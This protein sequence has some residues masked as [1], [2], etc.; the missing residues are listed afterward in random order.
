MRW[1][2]WLF[3]SLIFLSCFS[4]VPSRA[5]NSEQELFVV[6]QKAFEDGFYDIAPRY[7]EQLLKEYPRTEKRVPARLLLGQC[8]FF[9]S[10][11]LKA[12]EIFHELLEYSEFKDATLFWL[13]ETYLKGSDYLQAEKQFEQLI[14]VYPDSEYTPQAYYSLGWTYFAE[15]KL[16]EAQKTLKELLQK[17]PDHQFAEDALFKLGEIE[18]N[19]HNYKEAIGYFSDYADKYRDSA[20]I[21]E[22]YFYIG[23]AYYYLEDFLTAITYY[24]K[25]AQGAYDEKLTLM[26]K[27][28]L[29]WSYLKLGKYDLAKNNLEEAVEFSKQKGIASDDVYLGLASLYYEIKVYDQAMAAYTQLIENFADSSRLPEA[30]L[31]RANIYYQ[32]QKYSEAISDYQQVIAQF[33]NNSAYQEIVEKAYFGL[34][35][36]YLKIGKV[37][38]SIKT[39]QAIKDQSTSKTIK[40]SALTQIGDA[41]QDL[42]ELEKA[43]TV[44]DQILRDYP[45][46]VY[47]D[48]VQYRQGIALLKMERIEAATLSFQGL[49][50]NFPQSKYIHDTYYYLALAYFKK[51]NWAA[52]KQYINDFIKNLP[53]MDS[54]ESQAYY[55]LALSEFNTENYEEAL[56]IFQQ[57]IKKYP[58]ESSM[59]NNCEINVAKCYYKTDHAKEAL[60]IFKSLVER[61]PQSEI[62][63]ESLLWMGDHALE[64]LE[65][66]NAIGY[67]EK[68][69]R[70]FSG[71]D[72]KNIVL[73]HLAESYEGKEEYDQSIQRY[74]QID[75]ERDRELYTK[76]ELA[77]ADIF[78]LDIDQTK[79][80]ETYENIIKDSPEFKRDAYIKI[81]EVYA[82]S[83]EYARAVAAYQNAIQSPINLSEIPNAELQFFIGDS[84]ERLNQADKVTEEYLKI[85][86]LYPQETSW[87]VKA[88]LRI[89]RLLEK[90][91]KWEEAKTI[92]HKIIALKTDEMKFAQERLE[93]IKENIVGTRK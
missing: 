36:S 53:A 67:Y 35:W 90:Q 71:S 57:I 30:Y 79:A 85:P 21:A 18:Y 74:R 29:G 34:A 5:Q 2:K 73:Y 88:Y 7:I 44:Y 78:S 4:A 80:M 20:R 54:L 10:Q 66:D 93:W 31:G 39:F 77:I 22:S 32:Q 76:A 25:A 89:A 45:D 49:Q 58:E 11:Y 51:G 40:I 86:Y 75:K 70:D 26:A 91:E 6:A 19:L 82:E 48:Y 14:E 62:A 63:E 65:F 3:V 24:A 87:V 9:K 59:V 92:Y 23:E 41:Y 27:V 28:S 68:L 81:A 37:D 72:R 33:V 52:A 16:E 17:F 38:E 84:Y 50:A 1:R 47:A 61:Y 64:S 60:K 42:G 56:N 13:G 69:I 83:G 55:I 43:V 15:D 12:Y 8:Y 46:S